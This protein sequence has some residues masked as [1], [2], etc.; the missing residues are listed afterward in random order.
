MLEGSCFHFLLKARRK[1]TRNVLPPL[2]GQR[3]QREV[4]VPFAQAQAQPT[5]TAIVI[6]PGITIPIPFLKAQPG[7]RK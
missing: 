2:L 4:Q 6:S 1:K 7:S 5:A 3:L